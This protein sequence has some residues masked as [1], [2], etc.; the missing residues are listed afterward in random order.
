[1]IIIL[2]LLLL[3]LIGIT[4]FASNFDGYVLVV[5]VSTRWRGDRHFIHL[6]GS[7]IDLNRFLEECMFDVFLSVRFGHVQCF[8]EHWL[9]GRVLE[10]SKP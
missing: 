4:F 9:A 1:M 7:S 2:L 10:R 8:E 5:M 3:L 6:C